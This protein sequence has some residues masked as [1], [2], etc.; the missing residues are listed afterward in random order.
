MLESRCSR[1]SPPHFFQRASE[2]MEGRRRRRLHFP[3]GCARALLK[4]SLPR[5]FVP[6][7]QARAARQ[8]GTV[9]GNAVHRRPPPERG[10]I[11]KPEICIRGQTRSTCLFCCHCCCCCC[12]C[13]HCCCCLRRSTTVDSPFCLFYIYAPVIFGHRENAAKEVLTLWLLLRL[14][15]VLLLH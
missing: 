1:P 15:L 14:L 7:G 9:I 6:L 12:R 13:C 8:T 3:A 10:P 5:S 4:V 2:K 11:S